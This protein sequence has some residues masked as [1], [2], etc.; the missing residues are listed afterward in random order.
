MYIYIYIYAC[1][2]IYIYIYICIEIYRKRGG[3]K[4]QR[5][6]ECLWLFNLAPKRKHSCQCEYIS[7]MPVRY[8]GLLYGLAQERHG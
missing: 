6:R 5:E 2:Y 3:I 8:S 1:V 4:K 7:I